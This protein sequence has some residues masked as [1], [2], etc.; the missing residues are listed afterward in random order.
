MVAAEWRMTGTNDGPYMGLPPSGRAV[1]MPGADF[2]RV[3][4]DRVRSVTGYFDTRIVPEQ[5]GMQVVVQPH[6][7]GPFTFGT[8]V[9][10][11]GSGGEPGAMS[12][13]VLEARSDE[14]RAEVA[15]RSRDVVLEMLGM[16]GFIAWLGA[17]VGDQMFTVTAWERLEDPVRL[18]EESP[19]H[20]AA[21]ARFFGPDLARGG[22][23]GV[24]APHRLNGVWVRCGACSRMVPARAAETCTCGAPLPAAPRYW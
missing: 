1:S 15:D 13:T 4:G 22:Q 3:A 6:A 7:V 21:M 20:A 17:T 8:A 9:H 10:V 2:I 12:L 5:I 11:A 16:P 19:A 24:W 14:E 23:T 18:Q